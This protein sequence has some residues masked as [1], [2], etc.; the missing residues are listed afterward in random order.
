M[1]LTCEQLHGPCFVHSVFQIPPLAVH[2]SFRAP[3]RLPRQR[4]VSVEPVQQIL[5]HR[6]NAE[7]Q[8][9][10][11][12]REARRT[13]LPAPGRDQVVRIGAVLQQRVLQLVDCY[14]APQVNDYRAQ[15]AKHAH[16][17]QCWYSI[18][19]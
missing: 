12:A 11:E 14:A 3:A 16:R 18:L 15:H 1:L 10:A 5:R 9:S 6:R 4:V 13:T 8:G 2:D 7:A 19:I 17:T